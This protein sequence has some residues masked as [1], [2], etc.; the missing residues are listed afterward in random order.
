MPNIALHIKMAWSPA[1]VIKEHLIV[2]GSDC[3]VG[4]KVFLSLYTGP[5]GFILAFKL[6]G[7]KMYQGAGGG[8]GG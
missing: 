3:E 1:Q 6:G 8:G 2:T 5:A 4:V 7:S